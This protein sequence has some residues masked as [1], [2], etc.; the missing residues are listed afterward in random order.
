MVNV[1]VQRPEDAGS[2]TGRLLARGRGPFETVAE[3]RPTAVTR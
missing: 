1:Q 3:R 2:T